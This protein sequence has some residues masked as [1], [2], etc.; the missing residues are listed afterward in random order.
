MARVVLVA[1]RGALSQQLGATLRPGR[2]ATCKIGDSAVNEEPSAPL[3]FL[4]NWRISI[5][6]AASRRMATNT[7]FIWRR[8]RKRR[9]LGQCVGEPDFSARSQRIGAGL[10][11]YGNSQSNRLTPWSND[12]VSEGASEAFISATKRAGVFWTPT[13]L[14][15]RE[16]DAYRAR[17]GQGY[18]VFEHN[19]HAI[20]QELIVF[21]PIRWR[22]GRKLAADSRWR[23]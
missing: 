22:D 4:W 13:P 1:A 21:V 8:A 11:W 7:R 17:H 10:Y 2:A 5:R 9:A 23:V 19:S 18:S 6:S 3:P 15:I 14:P 20:E 12:P 16:N